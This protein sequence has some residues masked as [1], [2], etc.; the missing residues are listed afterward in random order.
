[1]RSDDQRSAAVGSLLDQILATFDEHDQQE[2]GG[3]MCMSS[4]ASFVGWVAHRLGVRGL[5]WLHAE[6]C[7]LKYDMRD[8][9]SENKDHGRPGPA[10]F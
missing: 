1:M 3:K 9:T 6:I 2:H 10:G 5:D 8:D 4:P 7:L